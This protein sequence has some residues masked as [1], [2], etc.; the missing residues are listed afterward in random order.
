[1]RI[2]ESRIKAI[3]ALADKLVRQGRND[4]RTVQQRRDA[5]NQRWRAMQGALSEYRQDLA[6]ALEIHAFNRDV[7]D[8]EG[9]I[10]EKTI[11]LNAAEEGKDL[12]Q[13]SFNSYL[14]FSLRRFVTFIFM[15]RKSILLVETYDAFLLG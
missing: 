3:N 14:F 15:D 8:T 12:P 10:S 11:L 4:S 6:G 7:D 13:V 5:L 1:M 2:D 9:R